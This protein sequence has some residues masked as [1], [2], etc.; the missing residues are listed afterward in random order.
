SEA[1]ATPNPAAAICIEAIFNNLNTSFSNASGIFDAMDAYNP[2]SAADVYDIFAGYGMRAIGT[3]NPTNLN[4]ALNHDLSGYFAPVGICIP[5][6]NPL[7]QIDA[8]NVN[9]LTKFGITD[10]HITG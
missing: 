1:N 4:T 7:N 3:G 9:Y 5:F 2:Q 6:I 8:F 10:I